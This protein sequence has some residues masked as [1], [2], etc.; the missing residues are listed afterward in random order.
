MIANRGAVAAALEPWNQRRRQVF[1]PKTDLAFD[2]EELRRRKQTVGE[3][4]LPK[5][6][7]LL[8]E[9]GEDIIQVQFLPNAGTCHALYH[10]QTSR[11]LLFF[12]VALEDPDFG[13]AIESWAMRKLG[14]LKLP[15]LEIVAFDVLS[16][17]L[18][19]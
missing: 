3:V 7:S 2:L 8:E 18:A 19:V 6:R 15:S 14:Q 13:F 10:V 1:Y 12:K 16:K 5:L 11:R 9:L 17:S 4:A